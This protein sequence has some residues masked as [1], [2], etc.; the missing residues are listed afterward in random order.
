MT[1]PA[2]VALD[3]EPFSD[4]ELDGY[5]TDAVVESPAHGWQ[6]N[7]TGEAEW[8]CAHLAETQTEI[9]KLHIQANEWY[10]NIAEWLVAESKRHRDTAEFFRGR[11]E[12]YGHRRRRE[13][14]RCKTITLPSG[15]V[16]TRTVKDRVVVEDEARLL[17]WLRENALEAVRVKE[18]VDIR[19]LRGLASIDG[20]EAHVQGEVLPGATVEPEHVEVTVSV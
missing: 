2:F 7:S 14:P 20:G 1:L 13:D 8:A 10:E 15:E 9:A 18:S 11:L 16:K 12:D 4:D 5:L 19:A 3:E 17:R 6:V